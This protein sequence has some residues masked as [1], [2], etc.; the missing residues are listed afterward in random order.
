[1]KEH[2]IIFPAT[3]A[4]ISTRA[5]NTL[6]VH[7]N[8]QELPSET[9]GSLFDLRN[10]FIKVLVTNKNAFSQDVVKVVEDEAFYS[11]KKPHTPSQ[12]LR[13]KIW[14]KYM[15]INKGQEYNRD[16]FDEYYRREMDVIINTY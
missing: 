14:S 11:Q 8:T 7:L 6:S 5:D 2:T 12:R 15:E 3:L 9:G 1:M 16:A 10:Q 13:H 4:R